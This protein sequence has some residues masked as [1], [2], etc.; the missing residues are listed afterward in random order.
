[1]LLGF[2]GGLVIIPLLEKTVME[3]GWLNSAEFP[4][5]VAIGQLST[6]PE[7]LTSLLLATKPAGKRGVGTDL[8][9][10]VWQWQPWLFFLPASP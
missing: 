3:M 2:G 9:L 7:I 1:M 10:R 6:G 8:G 5:G 4:D